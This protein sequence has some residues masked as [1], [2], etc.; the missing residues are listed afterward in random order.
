MFSYNWLTLESAI[1]AFQGIKR[2]Q[3]NKICYDT[4]LRN[5]G[6][7]YLDKQT[8]FAIMLVNNNNNIMAHS[9]ECYQKIWFPEFK[10]SKPSVTEA[11]VTE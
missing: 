10:F 8:D 7:Q 5:A 2:D 9:L 3:W 6:H 4:V 1:R 11:K